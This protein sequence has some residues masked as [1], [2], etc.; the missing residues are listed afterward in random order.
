MYNLFS[1]QIQFFYINIK[2]SNLTEALTMKDGVAVLA[3]FLK[4]KYPRSG[5]CCTCVVEGKSLPTAFSL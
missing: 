5:S 4:V 2:Y 1:F 3:V